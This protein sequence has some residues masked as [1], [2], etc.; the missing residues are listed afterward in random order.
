LPEKIMDSEALANLLWE[1]AGI[2]V[3]PELISIRQPKHGGKNGALMLIPREIVAA[4]ISPALKDTGI[5]CVAAHS[6]NERTR[7]KVITSRNGTTRLVT[8]EGR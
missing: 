3:P 6:A 7:S 5:Q 1:C 8:M 2:N 4:W